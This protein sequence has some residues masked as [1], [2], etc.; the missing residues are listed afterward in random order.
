MRLVQQ[1]IIEMGFGVHEI[2]NMDE[3]AC[4]WGLGPTHV[5]APENAERGEQEPTDEKARVTAAITGWQLENSY[6][7]SSY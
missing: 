2:A 7:V 3:T 1:L 5:F 4:N 6:L